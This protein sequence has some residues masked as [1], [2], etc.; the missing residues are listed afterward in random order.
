[1]RRLGGLGR[2]PSGRALSDG[3]DRSDAAR[4]A[5]LQAQISSSEPDGAAFGDAP[6]PRAGTGLAADVDALLGAANEALRAGYTDAVNDTVWGDAPSF[7]EAL[8]AAR[9]LD[10]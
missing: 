1:M 10:T 2:R 8:T 3:S 4:R 9:H 6:M 5:A 7:A